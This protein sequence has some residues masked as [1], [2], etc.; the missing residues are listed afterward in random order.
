MC[1][2]LFQGAVLVA[3]V[4]AIVLFK[5]VKG[6]RR[7]ISFLACGVT[8]MIGAAVLAQNGQCIAAAVPTTV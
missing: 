6:R 1:D 4:L 3:G 7:V 5:E 8:L 2:L